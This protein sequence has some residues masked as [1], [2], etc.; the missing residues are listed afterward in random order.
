MLRPRKVKYNKARKIRIRRTE[1]R[2]TKV[3]FGEYGLKVLDGGQISSR[4]IEAVRRVIVRKLKRTGKVW[5][6]IFPDV[7]VTAKPNEVR[8][9]RGKG[10]VD[11]WVAVVKPGT[12]IYEVGSTKEIAAQNAL[13]SAAKKLSMKCSFV[14]R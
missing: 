2:Q 6:R 1:Q 3:V 9:G 14:K 8:M 5:I 7:P 13:M 11:K 4:Q 12:V 10:S